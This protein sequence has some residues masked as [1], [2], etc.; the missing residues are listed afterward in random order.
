MKILAA[1]GLFVSLCAF[2]LNAETLNGTISEEHC[3]AKHASAT[4]ADQACVKK[5]MEGGSA[6]VFVSGEKVYKIE[7]P[8][9]VKGHEGHRVSIDGK[10]TGDSVHVDSVKMMAEK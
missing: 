9:A 2:G 8:D 3:G 4:E 7:N 1:T 5:C 6:A 10:L